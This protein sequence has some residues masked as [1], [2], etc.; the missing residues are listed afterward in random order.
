MKHDF[1][2]FRIDSPNLIYRGSII[3]RFSSAI[4]DLLIPGGIL[5]LVSIPSDHPTWGE[6]GNDLAGYINGILFL[7]IFFLPELFFRKTYGMLVMN[8]TV[9]PPVDRQVWVSLLIRKFLNLIE[10]FLPSLIY[11][12]VTAMSKDYA[13]LSDRA[14]GCIIAREAVLNRKI[15]PPKDLSKASRVLIAVIFSFLPIVIIP[16]VIIFVL[17]CGIGLEL[18]GKT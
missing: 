9:I 3:R 1:A 11:F 12:W 10:L 15:P 7:S 18:F 6:S 8:L 4:I 16:C 2:Q 14:S 17:V 13:S 5:L